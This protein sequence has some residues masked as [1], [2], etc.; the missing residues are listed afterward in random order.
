[1]LTK[2]QQRQYLSEKGHQW[3]DDLT[4]FGKTQDEEALHRL[5]LGVKKIKA[6]VRLSET[7]Q[8]KRLAKDFQPL[9][10][11]FRQAGIIRDTKNQ[12]RLLEQ[13]N[14]LSPEYKKRQ[15]QRVQAITDNFSRHVKKYRRKG[16]K[17][18][19]RLF[20]DVRAIRCGPI[21][22]WFANEI[23]RTGILLSGSGDDLHQTCDL[24]RARDLHQARKKIKTMLYV[25][26]I[27]PQELVEQLRLD[28]DY[29]DQLQDT[30]GKWHDTLVA[31][32]DWPAEQQAGE[33][34]MVHECRE[35]EQAIRLL[36]DDFHR[37]THR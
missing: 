8:G 31:A 6:L 20:A 4:A 7:V 14:L 2:K 25:Q 11:M 30:I 33:R 36:A 3:L 35:K 37:K 12:L 32:A 27:L 21:R 18:G 22:R 24:Y 26:K 17:A 23:I 28:R 13:R 29:L 16:Q 15:V 34:Q 19:R 9:K 10:K 1:M 5:R